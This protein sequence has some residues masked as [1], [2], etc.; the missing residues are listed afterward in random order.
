VLLLLSSGKGLARRTMAK[1]K[2]KTS[3]RLTQT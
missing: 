1:K 2:K 3:F